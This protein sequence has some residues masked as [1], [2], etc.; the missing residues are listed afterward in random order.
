MT[1][2]ILFGLQVT[3]KFDVYLSTSRAATGKMNG[4]GFHSTTHGFNMPFSLD[5]LPPFPTRRLALHITPH[6]ERIVRQGHPWLFGD[7]IVRQN[8]VG[9]A[10]DLAVIFDK[11]D[12]FLAIGLYDPDSPVRVKILHH[13]TT[14][15]IDAAWLQ[16]RVEQAAARRASLPAAG[17]TGYR[18][19]HGENDGFPGLIVDRYAGCCVLKLYSAVWLPYLREMVTLLAAQPGVAHIVLRLSRHLQAR[20]MYGLSDGT[21]LYGDVPPVPLLFTENGLTFAVDVIAGHKTGIFL[22]SAR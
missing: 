16:T 5:T 10:G 21:L 19:I 11:K 9:E 1:D 17:T 20:A 18:L 12:R 8:H 6:A 22:R 3:L 15:R 4:H 14:V 2:S 7:S 13:G